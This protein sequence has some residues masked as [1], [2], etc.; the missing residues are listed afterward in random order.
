MAPIIA[1]SRQ[2]FYCYGLLKKDGEEARC[3]VQAWEITDSD[4]RPL[5]HTMQ[6]IIDVSKRLPDGVYDL[7]ALGQKFKVCRANGFWTP[8]RSDLRV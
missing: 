7:E 6:R 4:G 3:T 5:T 2:L 1:S 8:V